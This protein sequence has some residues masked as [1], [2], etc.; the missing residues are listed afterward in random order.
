[1]IMT[2]HRAYGVVLWEI[3]SFAMQPYFGMTHE[4]VVKFIKDGNMLNCP[5]NTPLM[6]YN[7][8]MQTWN[9]KS[10]ERPTFSYIS[11]TL[12]QICLDYDN[13]RGN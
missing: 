10:N 12:L 1:M 6:I 5:E 9:R 13:R 2:F 11:Q 7:L 3:F 8:M 4:E